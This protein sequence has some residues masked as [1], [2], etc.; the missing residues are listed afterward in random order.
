MPKESFNKR[1]TDFNRDGFVMLEDAL[2]ECQL[3]VM[4]HQLDRWIDISRQYSWYQCNGEK[5]KW[6]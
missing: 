4:R 3:E 6:I 1:L 5:F 2:T